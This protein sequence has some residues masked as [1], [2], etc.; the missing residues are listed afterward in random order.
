MALL[1]SKV[2]KFI[3]KI[4]RTAIGRIIFVAI[5]CAPCYLSHIYQ[6]IKIDYDSELLYE[7]RDELTGA[8]ER[9]Y[10]K[11]KRYPNQLSDLVPTYL[12]VLPKH[13]RDLGFQ[14]RKLDEQVILSYGVPTRF[15]GYPTGKRCELENGNH[16]CFHVRYYPEVNQVD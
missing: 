8:L 14:Y 9:F 2:L 7:Q 3:L 4:G 10:A 16:R 12:Q 1:I 15:P 13:P 6:E 11:H 5:L